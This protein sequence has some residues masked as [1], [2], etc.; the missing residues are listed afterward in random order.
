V[1]VKNVSVLTKGLFMAKK[2]KNQVNFKKDENR[3]AVADVLI[4]DKVDV[5]V[6]V[7]NKNIELVW[8]FDSIKE[9]VKAMKKMGYKEQ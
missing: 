6:C 1:A 3:T 7:A 5:T 8:H 9:A 2:V 4:N